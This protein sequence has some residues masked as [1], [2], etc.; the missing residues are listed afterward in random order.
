[1]DIK[2]IRALSDDELDE[3]YYDHLRSS[4]Q[5]DAAGFGEAP[6]FD[7]LHYAAMVRDERD[8]R[9]YV[10]LWEAL[11]AGI[12]IVCLTLLAWAAV[13]LIRGENAD[14][15]VAG[16]GGIASGAASV[17]ILS[18]VRGARH[19]LASTVEKLEQLA[20]G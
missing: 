2:E 12:G 15:I 16:V 9:R 8:R 18:R 11:L 6:Q 3:R 13:S 1:M 4:M 7:E 19:R 10:N 5:N 17:W 20:R 14:G